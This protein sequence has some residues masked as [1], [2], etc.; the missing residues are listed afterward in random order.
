[1]IASVVIPTTGD[2]VALLEHSVRS[3]L[4]Q[5][6]EDLEVLVIGD[7]AS[8]ATRAWAE[9]SDR[10]VRFFG[11]AKDASRGEVN[12]HRVLRDSA[13][14][15]LVLY[16]CDRDL[17]LP[18]H[19]AE[20]QQVLADAD[21]GHTLRFTVGE[22]DR[23]SAP[24]TIDLRRAED[25][26]KAWYTTNVLPLSMAGHTRAAYE[27]LPHGWRTT[28][29]DRPTDRHMW[30]Q[31]LD[32]ADI[33]V[34][35]CAWPTAL[36]FKRPASWSVDQRREV[37]ERWSPRLADPDLPTILARE[38]LEVSTRE[39]SVLLRDLGAAR[40]SRIGGLARQVLPD[41]AYQQVRRPARWARRR[42]RRG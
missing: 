28:P 13:E 2:R 33:R 32:Q 30:V 37:L 36:S 39:G 1:V 35:S 10:R 34:A 14:G 21:F 18:G 3:V 17:W 42:L 16:L 38:L 11:F 23:L 19:V 24:H 15:E 31:F 27:R 41:S 9:A 25:R 20:M 8:E 6:V 22:D 40:A 12:R 5:S 29:P 26:A 4:A 7:G